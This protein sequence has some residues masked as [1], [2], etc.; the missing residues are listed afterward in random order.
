MNHHTEE[1]SGPGQQS[2]DRIRLM[3]RW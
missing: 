3:K 2:H 1:S